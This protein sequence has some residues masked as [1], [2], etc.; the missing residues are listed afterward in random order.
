MTN[1][2]HPQSLCAQCGTWRSLPCGEGCSWKVETD[3]VNGGFRVSTSVMEWYYRDWKRLHNEAAELRAENGSFKAVLDQAAGIITDR[4]KELADMVTDLDTAKSNTG[5][6]CAEIATLRA[7][8]ERQKETL[9]WIYA[10]RDNDRRIVSEVI[11]PHAAFSALNAQMCSIFERVADTLQSKEPDN[12][13]VVPEPSARLKAFYE[14]LIAGE[15][16]CLGHSN[17]DE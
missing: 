13:P 7:E 9:K 3:P 10:Q 11:N 16:N 5:A 15:G 8:N 12:K 1:Q 14:K 17:E 2:D 6:A 4:N